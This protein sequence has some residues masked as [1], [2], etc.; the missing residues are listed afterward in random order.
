MDHKTGAMPNDFL[1]DVAD[2]LNTSD[3]D[4]DYDDTAI[5]IIMDKTHPH[6]DKIQEL[7]L[8]DFD[9]TTG[10]AARKKFNVIMKVMKLMKKM[11]MSG[12]HDNDENFVDVAIKKV[13]G[14]SGLLDDHWM[15]LFLSKVLCK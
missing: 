3:D 14:T 13:P 4:D 6:F 9:N 2:A 15:L 1:S 5:N 11:T 10:P 7:N 12:E 8:D